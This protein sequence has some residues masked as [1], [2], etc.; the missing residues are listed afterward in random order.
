M[1]RDMDLIR[2]LLLVWEELD[3][4]GEDHSGLLE[5]Y[6]GEQIGYHA[7]LLVDAG[8]AR[9]ADTSTRAS[10]LPQCIL[11]GLTWEGHEFI[12]AARDEQHWTK[13]K[14]AMSKAGGFSVSVMKELLI[15]Y[16]KQKVLGTD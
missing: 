9:G 3:G 15:L 4:T 12:D 8:L 7:Y 10:V 16:L 11:T 5:G 6:T 13:A 2:K 14:G 1:K